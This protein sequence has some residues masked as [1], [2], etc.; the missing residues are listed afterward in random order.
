VDRILTVPTVT[1]STLYVFFVL[2]LERRRIA[3]PALHVRAARPGAK[4][5]HRC[6]FF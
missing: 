5:I 2:S 1:F 6:R 3:C 4:M